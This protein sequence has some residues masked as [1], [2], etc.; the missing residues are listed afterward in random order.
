MIL[1]APGLWGCC[2][3]A[4]GTVVVSIPLVKQHSRGLSLFDQPQLVAWWRRL[5]S[6]PDPGIST[7]RLLSFEKN[8]KKNRKRKS[9]L[10][11]FMLLRSVQIVAFLLHWYHGSLASV[12]LVKVLCTSIGAEIK[13]LVNLTL[14]LS[15]KYFA[16]YK[17]M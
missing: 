16:S 1:Q 4:A 5:K 3:Q 13:A 2:Q 6:E 8:L 7:C 9:T 11:V 14:Q 12:K 10:F 15:G 17:Q